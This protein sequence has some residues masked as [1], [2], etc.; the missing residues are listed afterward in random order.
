MNCMMGEGKAWSN[1]TLLEPGIV[2]SWEV[3]CGSFHRDRGYQRASFD[4]KVMNNSL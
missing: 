2:G 1:M 4:G 3:Q